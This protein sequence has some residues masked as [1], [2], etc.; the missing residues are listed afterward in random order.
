MNAN[1]SSLEFYFSVKISKKKK[2]QNH[3]CI[4]VNILYFTVPTLML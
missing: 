4:D 1:V 2:S 3:G